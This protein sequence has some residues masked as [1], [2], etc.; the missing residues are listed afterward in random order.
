[1]TVL[2]SVPV[3][4][5]NVLGGN[6]DIAGADLRQ[7][8]REQAAQAET[9]EHLLLVFGAEAVLGGGEPAA[10]L[11][12]GDIAPDVIEGFEAEVKGLGCRRTE[13]AVRIVQGAEQ[14]VLLVAAAT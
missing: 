9:T 1:M 6:L 8:A 13:Q 12:T 4:E 5:G 11:V 3:E 2:V 7:A 10:R 14:G